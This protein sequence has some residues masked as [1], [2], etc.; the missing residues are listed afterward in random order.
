MERPRGGHLAFTDWA[1]HR[2]LDKADCESMWRGI[3]AQSVQ[4]FVSYRQMLREIGFRNVTIEDLTA[5]WGRILEER[6]AMYCQLREENVRLGMPAGDEEFYR[7]Y[8]RLVALVQEGTLGG[9][10]FTA[11]K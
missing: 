9:G 3:A 4:S 7:S 8:A 5:D 1:E 11:E 10:R 2:R 6:F